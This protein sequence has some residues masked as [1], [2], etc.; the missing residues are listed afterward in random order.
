MLI[1]L[2]ELIKL[3]LVQTRKFFFKELSKSG[4][5]AVSREGPSRT[6]C[7]GLTMAGQE[8]VSGGL[9]LVSESPGG[10]QA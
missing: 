7:Y 3:R 10:V 1:K 2:P 8:L 6:R 4:C 9:G 5:M